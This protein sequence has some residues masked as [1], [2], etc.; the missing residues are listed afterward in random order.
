MCKT[1][2][3]KIQTLKGGVLLYSILISFI[4]S[5]FCGAIMLLYYY[6][7]QNVQLFINNEKLKDE[8]E[9]AIQ[10][11]LAQAGKF[12]YNNEYSFNLY[13]E[14]FK[15]TI[16]KRPWGCFNILSITS[17]TQH[18][19]VLKSVL[20][21]TEGNEH[22]KTALMLTDNTRQLSVC[23]NIE[24]VG[25]CYLPLPSVK[26]A[27]VEGRFLE[28]SNI[29]YELIVAG[30]DVLPDLNPLIFEP[31]KFME[32]R[33]ILVNSKPFEAFDRIDTIINSF[34]SPTLYIYQNKGILLSNKMIKGNVVIISNGRIQIEPNCFIHDAIFVAS[35]IEIKSI[36]KSSLQAYALNKI[37]LKGAALD[38]PSS[39]IV[40]SNGIKSKP[41]ATIK[42]EGGSIVS[43][44]V[45]AFND[46]SGK[47][48]VFISD[49]S[50]VEGTVYTNG[51]VEHRGKI[52]GGVYCAR[53]IYRIR[54]NT[55]ENLLMDASIKAMDKPD[56]F[57]E[58]LLFS[59]SSN[60]DIVKCLN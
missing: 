38:Y 14:P 43:G 60:F 56:C 42:V 24:L 11:S 8:V 57:I 28:K 6:L 9:S 41:Q 7:N 34:N 3:R 23:G 40:Y 16:K 18:D 54:K 35:E 17:R 59:Y 10:Y 4:V 32:E 22:K 30:G 20:I 13:P 46:F 37:E 31:I 2:K 1:D 53:T 48:N 36:R 15:T 44:A 49:N 12:D 50:Q 58:P 47:G 51:N 27:S 5:V 26:K 39:L 52:R 29:S 45:V 33:E 19:T 25:N 55:Y 21:G